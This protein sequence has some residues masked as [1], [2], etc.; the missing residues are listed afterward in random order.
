MCSNVLDEVPQVK[1][2]V[3]WECR[4]CFNLTP[5]WK[6]F[7]PSLP[8][9]VEIPAPSLETCPILK[10]LIMESPPA[11]PQSDIQNCPKLKKMLMAPKKGFEIQN[12]RNASYTVKTEQLVYKNNSNQ[13]KQNAKIEIF[14]P[15]SQ[16]CSPNW[17]FSD[18]HSNSLN[19]SNFHQYPELKP[20]FD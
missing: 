20:N 19:Y 14:E 1:L 4:V 7:D 3:F 8:L 9:K 6:N 15:N 2:G 18:Y 11:T 17:N 13:F 16:I 12:F 5:M 10:S